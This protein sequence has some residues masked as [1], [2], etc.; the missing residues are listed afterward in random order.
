MRCLAV[1]HSE[2]VIQLLEAVLTPNA[3]LDVLV[4][5]RALA[6][7][8]EH[9]DVSVSV[10]EVD[11][12]DS[13]VKIGVS[14]VMPV[15]IEDNGRK[16]LRKILEAVRDAGGTLIYVIG[17][18]LPDVRKAEALRGDF[19]EVTTLTLAELIGPPLMRSEEHTSELQ[20][21]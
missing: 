21:H 3:E 10:D 8:F 9:A 5:S 12:I 17:T 20:S 16:G 13:Y 1:C 14:P 6:R 7:K 18:S 11:R 4:E 19:P 2:L 15:F